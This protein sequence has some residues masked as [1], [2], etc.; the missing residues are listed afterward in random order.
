MKVCDYNHLILYAKGHYKKT[1]TVEDVRKILAVRCGIS[2]EL[3]ADDELWAMCVMALTTY[4]S[5]P[6]VDRVMQGLFSKT[7]HE[8]DDVSELGAPDNVCPLERAVTIVL[9]A[10]FL[11]D[12]EVAGSTELSLGE[13]DGTIL[14]LSKGPRVQYIGGGHGV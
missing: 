8:C 2:P 6:A 4:G 5:L 7:Q 3:I 14:A 11:V 9:R 10:L 1:D 13:P 12:V